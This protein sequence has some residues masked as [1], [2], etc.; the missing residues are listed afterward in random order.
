MS[1]D[2]V[3]ELPRTKHGHDAIWVVVDR[4]SKMVH[5]A[6]TTSQVT[7]LDTANLFLEHVFDA[8][9]LPREVIFDR[10]PQFSGHFWRHLC[11]RLSIKPALSTT[12]RLQTDGQIEHMNRVIEDT[13]R[14]YVGPRQDTW[15]DLLP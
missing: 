5:I 3:V 7:A 4:F 10:G 13:L 8:H 1:M 14:H 2:F 9:G 11:T 6:P 15:D 12:F